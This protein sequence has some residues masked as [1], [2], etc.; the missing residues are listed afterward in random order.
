M[1]TYICI[2][3]YMYTYIYTYTCIYMCIYT[4]YTCNHNI[5]LYIHTRTYVGLVSVLTSSI[6]ESQV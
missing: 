2:N 4:Q 1:Y 3:T 5:Y 6:N